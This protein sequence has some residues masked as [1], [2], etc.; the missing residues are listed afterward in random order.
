V[1]AIFTPLFA[2]AM[3]Q[4]DPLAPGGAEGSF[5]V[6]VLP[7]TRDI[8]T[9]PA[10]R[11]ILLPFVS[12]LSGKTPRLC[13]DV[14]TSNLFKNLVSPYESAQLLEF[15]ASVRISPGVGLQVDMGAYAKGDPPLE[16]FSS[17]VWHRVSG[18][19]YSYV[20][21]SFSLPNTHPFGR[22][23]KAPTVGNPRPVFFFVLTGAVAEST[24]TD[25]IVRGLIRFSVHGSGVMEA[26]VFPASAPQKSAK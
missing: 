11:E 24:E 17:P 16:F 12:L 19:T 6:S 26:L 14:A 1:L 5:P 3:P 25:A 22:E 10:P 21:S 7:S 2:L 9:A 4:T 15:S 18:A 13:F 20:E 8:T 23:L